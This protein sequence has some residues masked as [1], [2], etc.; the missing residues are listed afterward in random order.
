MSGRVS[1]TELTNDPTDPATAGG[2]SDGLMR[3]QGFCAYR[4]RGRGRCAGKHR[5]VKG[6][7]KRETTREERVYDLKGK[8]RE[9]HKDQKR[10]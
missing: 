2:I 6:A 10:R 8:E 4:G 1:Q 9:K 3:P 5:E 7:E